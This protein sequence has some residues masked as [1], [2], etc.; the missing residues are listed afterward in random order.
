MLNFQWNYE[1]V[2][3]YLNGISERFYAFMFILLQQNPEDGGGPFETQPATVRGNCQNI[4]NP[5]NFPLGYF[6]ASEVAEF[7]YT[8]Q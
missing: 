1:F 5:D 7:I 6:R 8:I 3:A 4:T 2:N